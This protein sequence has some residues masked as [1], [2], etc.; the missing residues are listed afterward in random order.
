VLNLQGVGEIGLSPR[1]TKQLARLIE[2]GG[3]ARTL[4]ITKTRSGA[5]RACVGFR[6]VATKT[7]ARNDQV[8]GVDRGVAVTC[9]LPDGSCW[10]V[11]VLGAE[12]RDEIARL[13][14]LREQHPKFSP[15][16]K[17]A[18]RAIAKAYARAHRRSETGAATR[19]EKWSQVTGSWPSR[20]SNSP[21]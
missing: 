8:G 17:K 5:W 18:N 12:A 10:C 11:R 14:R 15:A 2:R 4:T 7:L 6:G 13:G 16:W 9:A 19:P 20:T 21:R 1:A 3:E